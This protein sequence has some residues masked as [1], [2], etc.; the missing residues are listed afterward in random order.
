MRHRY[1]YSK[2][3]KLTGQLI[4][5]RGWTKE[6]AKSR[7]KKALQAF[8][9]MSRYGLHEVD[10]FGKHNGKLFVRKNLVNWYLE[11]NKDTA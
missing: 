2:Y 4:E 9:R 7:F 8:R 3:F 11:N 1:S 10:T 5:G 6:V